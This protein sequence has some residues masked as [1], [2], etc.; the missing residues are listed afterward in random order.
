MTTP[1]KKVS[2]K[3][4]TTKP[5]TKKSKKNIVDAKLSRVM[6]EQTGTPSAKQHSSRKKVSFPWWGLFAFLLILVLGG[7]LLYEN[8]TD[9]RSNL[10]KMLNSTGIVTVETEEDSSTALFTDTA[11]FEMKLTIVYNKENQYMKDSIDQYLK[12]LEQNLLNTKVSPTW[13]DKSDEGGNAMIEKVDAKFLPIFTTDVTIKN[14]PQ[15]QLFGPA[16]TQINGEYVFQ[17]EGMEYLQLPE[18][19]DATYLGADPASAKVVIIEYA[20]FSCGYCK[21]MHQILNNVLEKYSADVSLVIK[22]FDRGGTDSILAQ[23]AECAVEQNRFAEMESQLYQKQSDFFTAMQDQEDPKSAITDL[24]ETTA[25]EA[26]L[27]AANLLSCVDSGKYAE[28]IAKHTTEG[29]AFGVLGTPGFFI[30]KKFL[31]GAT[32]EATFM[33]L[34]EEEL[35]K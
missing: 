15:Y 30:N 31:G 6:E 33:G 17:S 3:R 32:D 35:K 1:K 19:G 29:R 2:T 27:N 21:A 11:P 4:K 20:S 26:G 24:L 16:I 7:I 10:V 12:N 5:A 18:T 34:I 8:N 9:F 28:K 13:L 23:A 22:H 25:S 14:H